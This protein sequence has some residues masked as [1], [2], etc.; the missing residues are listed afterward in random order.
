VTPSYPYADDADPQLVASLRTAAH[1]LRHPVPVADLP[2]YLQRCVQLTPD[3]TVEEI[4]EHTQDH[5]QADR[6]D[7][8][9][10]V[11]GVTEVARAVP[12]EEDEVEA[13]EKRRETLHGVDRD[14]LGLT[15]QL[16]GSG[17]AA[18]WSGRLSA[19]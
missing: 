18:D 4:S 3:V 8:Q 5:V 9:V 15:P 16:T 13:P 2:D 12:A 10:A 14:M 7:Q 19:A 17:K 11:P 6:N 1:L